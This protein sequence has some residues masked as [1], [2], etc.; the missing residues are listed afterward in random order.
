[1]SIQNS[2]MRDGIWPTQSPVNNPL[3]KHS[4]GTVVMG[5]AQA[6]R[7]GSDFRTVCF[8]FKIIG[9]ILMTFDFLSFT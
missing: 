5:L 9:W 6:F 8:G 2:P 1:M 7:G 3:T 4:V